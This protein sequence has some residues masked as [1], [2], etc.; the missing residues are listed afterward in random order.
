IPIGTNGTPAFSPY[1]VDLM[2]P[3]KLTSSMIRPRIRLG[4][5]TSVKTLNIGTTDFPLFSPTS[6]VSQRGLGLPS[7]GDPPR[8]RKVALS[9]ALEAGT[10]TPLG[11]PFDPSPTTAG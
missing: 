8:S 10:V 11:A 6:L 2:S 4:S 1:A 7:D 9:T 5:G 3:E